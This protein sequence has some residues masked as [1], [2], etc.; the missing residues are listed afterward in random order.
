MQ[1]GVTHT[2]CVEDSEQNSEPVNP[3]EY[4]QKFVYNGF[5][6]VIDVEKGSVFHTGLKEISAITITA[7][8]PYTVHE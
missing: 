8:F 6:T 1:S 2:I 5:I 4:F 7:Q 3:T